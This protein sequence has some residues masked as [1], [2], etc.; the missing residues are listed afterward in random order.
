MNVVSV[1]GS[2]F[3]PKI[4]DNHNTVL[5][6]FKLSVQNFHTVCQN[7]CIS[8]SWSER[9][10]LVALACREVLTLALSL[11]CTY[12]ESHGFLIAQPWLGLQS[13]NA[14]LSYCFAKSLWACAHLILLTRTFHADM[15]LL[16]AL[17][18]PV[19]DENFLRLGRAPT[20]EGGGGQPFIWV[21]YFCRK[22]H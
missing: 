3:E 5:L 17:M 19:V 7:M 6:L 10:Y 15:T 14:A 11:Q 1:Q 20:L 2:I 22:V 12:C 13:A 18:F 8:V 21:N 4:G 16:H 9:I